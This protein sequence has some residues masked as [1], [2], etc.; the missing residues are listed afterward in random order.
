VALVGAG[1]G[2][3][4]L[5][6]VRGRRLLR[7][8]DVVVYDRL[9]TDALLAYAPPGARRIFAGKASGDHALRQQEINALLI[10]HAQRGA[11]V[12]RLKGGDPFVF[13]RGGEEA[14]ALAAA[15][16]PFEVVPGVSAAIAA[17]SAAGI[18][19][20]HRGLASS[21]AVVTGHEDQGKGAARVDWRALATGVDTLVVLMGWRSM[22]RI[23]ADLIAGGRSSR[24]PVALVESATTA[25]QRVVVSTLGE[26]AAA[27]TR[28]GLKPPVTMIVGDVVAIR[29]RLRAHGVR[30]SIPGTRRRRLRA[31][32][33]GPVVYGR[34]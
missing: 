20:T 3:P 17:P 28:A 7:H 10:T 32:A 22:P 29:D 30:L 18:P 5:L 23:G 19:L 33:A 26:A 27:A 16:V 25:R 13:S 14:E 11:R 6:T 15:G 12:V 8:A 4:E 31:G 2:D 34:A 9:A 21:F 24:T 1:P